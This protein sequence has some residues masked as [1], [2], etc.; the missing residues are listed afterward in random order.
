MSVQYLDAAG[1]TLYE[2]GFTYADLVQALAA[3]GAVQNTGIYYHTPRSA[4][5]T[6]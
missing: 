3:A 2:A 5:R 4:T 6:A 1:K